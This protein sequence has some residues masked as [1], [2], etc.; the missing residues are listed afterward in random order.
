MDWIIRFMVGN[1]RLARFVLVALPFM[2]AWA[3]VSA[4]LRWAPGV[5]E[6]IKELFAD[7]R[8]EFMVVGVIPGAVMA[9]CMTV[10]MGIHLWRSSATVFEDMED[11]EDVEDVDN[12]VAIL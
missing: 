10:V 8:W 3:V 9:L 6:T 12:T 1:Q 5:L 4:V 7:H 2:M 11:V